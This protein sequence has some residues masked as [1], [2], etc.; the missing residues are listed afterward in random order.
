MLKMV[1]SIGLFFT[2]HYI[3]SVSSVIT[4]GM[5]S[6]YFKSYF[7]CRL[8]NHFLKEIFMYNMKNSVFP[9]IYLYLDGESLM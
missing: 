4:V 6:E 7:Q 3:Y 8:L 9:G 5:T 2:M 1:I